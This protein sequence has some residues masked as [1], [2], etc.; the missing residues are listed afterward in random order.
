[1][2]YYKI[3]VNINKGDIMKECN[4]KSNMVGVKLFI[5]I[6]VYST[7]SLIYNFTYIDLIY[8][9]IV[10]GYFAVY[11]KKVKII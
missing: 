2:W 8:L 3:A 4:Q 11:L 5:A 7:L 9:L 1:M 6:I 10:V